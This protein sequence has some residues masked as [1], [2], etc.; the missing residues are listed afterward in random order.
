MSLCLSNVRTIMQCILAPLIEFVHQT[1]FQ[2]WMRSAQAHDSI[3]TTFAIVVF[4]I[5]PWIW[6]TRKHQMKNSV[7]I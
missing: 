5:L 4:E 7:C 1:Y 6:K 2:M 3:E